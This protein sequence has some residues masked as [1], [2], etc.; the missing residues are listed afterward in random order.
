MKKDAFWTMVSASYDPLELYRLI[1]W[2]VLKQTEDQHPF[3]AVHEQSLAVLNTK[4][5]GL[6]KTQWYER[7]NTRHDVAHPVGVE[8]RHKVLWEYCAQSKHSMSYNALGTTDQAAM[9]QAA[10]D[11]Y[12]AYILLLNSGG[13]HKHLRK[14]LQ[15]NFTKGSNKYPENCSQ[16]LLFLDRFSKSAPADSASQG[17]AFTQ[18]G[19]QPNKGKEKKRSNKFKAIKKDFDKEYF[20]DLPCFKCGKKGHSQSHCLTKTNDEDNS[21]ISSKSNRSSKSG[22]KPN[23]KDFENQFKNLK[24]SFAQLKSAQEGN[25]SSDSSEE[26]LHFQYGSRINRGGCLPKALMDMA[27]K[28]SMKGL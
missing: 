17:T 2:V 26:M 4:Q 21:Y 9:H 10:E 15:N 6:S 19:G 5:G 8:L 27:F 20:K 18:K 14:E 28:Q 23:I 3:T 24:K 16:T 7:F 25:L 12:L 22:G 1:E 11:R 13:Q